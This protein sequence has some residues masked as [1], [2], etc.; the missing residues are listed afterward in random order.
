MPVVVT[1]EVG[2]ASTVSKVGAGI[3][4]AG[5]AAPLGAAIAELLASPAGRQEM[6]RAGRKAAEE[7]F[8][9]DAIAMQM[10]AVYVD[11]R[12]SVALA[13]IAQR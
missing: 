4:V 11:A 5:D 1:P 2:L 6:G 7:L 12:K 10:K 9:W 3:V 8:S 13:T